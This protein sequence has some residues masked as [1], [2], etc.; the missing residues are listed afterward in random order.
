[1]DEITNNNITYTTT[2][3]TADYNTLTF[4]T[5]TDTTWYPF[6]H[7]IDWLPY[8]HEKYFPAFHLLKSY[9]VTKNSQP[10]LQR[11]FQFW[12]LLKGLT[13]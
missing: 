7:Y 4:T 3:S 9:G 10:R 1:M 6:N 8:N 2:A 13:R 12:A 5:G 11:V